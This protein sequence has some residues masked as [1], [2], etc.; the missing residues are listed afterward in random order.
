MINVLEISVVAN[1]QTKTLGHHF[2]I[3]CFTDYFL[4]QVRV[5]GRNKN[6]NKIHLDSFP[7]EL[8]SKI[9]LENGPNKFH[10]NS[11]NL[12]AEEKTKQKNIIELQYC[13]YFTGMSRGE[14]QK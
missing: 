3:F 8:K 9:Q 5:G 1:T 12:A 14:I 13:Q 6:K 2:F 10:F 7:L 11:I 4:Q